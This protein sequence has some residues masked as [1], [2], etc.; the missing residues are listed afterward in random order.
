MPNS[1]EGE[2]D[3]H[4]SSHTYIFTLSLVYLLRTKENGRNSFTS[5]NR[6]TKH[7][8]LTLTTNKMCNMGSSSI[9]INRRATLMQQQRKKGLERNF[10]NVN[11]RTTNH[12]HQKQHWQ[13]NE[14][15]PI[16]CVAKCKIP[17]Q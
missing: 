4:H 1:K 3:A 12:H 8:Q 11:Q 10:K 15:H 6:C 7:H 13:T 2:T 17:I 14:T 9:S 16:Y 5:R